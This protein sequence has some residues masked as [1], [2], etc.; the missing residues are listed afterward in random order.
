VIEKNT[1]KWLRQAIEILVLRYNVNIQITGPQ[2]V[3]TMTENVF[4]W[5]LLVVP[6]R[7]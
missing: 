2:I 6:R 3:G 4:I 1:K 7:R 5:L